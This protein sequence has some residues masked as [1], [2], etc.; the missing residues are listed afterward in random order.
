MTAQ[1]LHQLLRPRLGC[2]SQTRE[3]IFV[4]GILSTSPVEEGFRAVR[5]VHETGVM[6]WRVEVVVPHVYQNLVL[7]QK[8]EHSSMS[9]LGKTKKKQTTNTNKKN[10]NKTNEKKKLGCL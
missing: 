7:Q 9:M 1:K 5:S 6:E 8:A 2:D 4:S 3:A 10:K